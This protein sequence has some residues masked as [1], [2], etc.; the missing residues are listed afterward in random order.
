MQAPEL[1]N[2]SARLRALD[3]AR[4]LDT[5]SEKAYDDLVRLASFICG[6]P[7]SLISLVDQKRQWFKARVGLDVKETAR[8]LA[9]CAHTILKPDGLTV[10]EDAAADARFADNPLVTGDPNIRFYAGAPLVTRDG[11]ALGSLCVIDRVPRTLTPQQVDAL[12]TIRTQ[13][14]REM[15]LRR[16][17]VDL[18]NSYAMLE[19]TQG[20]VRESER[21]YRELVD[22]SLGLICVHD[23]EGTLTLVNPAVHERLGYLPG[24]LKGKNLASIIAPA[25]RHLFPDYLRRI[26]E[27]LADSGLMR[28]VT[29]AG[30]ERVWHYR[31]VL[32]LEDNGKTEVIGHAEDVTDSQ[33]L[34]RTLRMQ[35]AQD[36]LTKLFNRRYLEDAMEREI[37]KALRR[38]RSVSLLMIDVDF[39]KRIN[40]SH[41]HAA[42]DKVLVALANFLKQGI[43]AEDLACRYGGDEFVVVLTEAGMQGAKVR[44]EK[45]RETVKA[46][47][48]THEATLI[49]GLSLSIGVAAYPANGQ[50]LRELLDAADKALYR[51][52]LHGRDQVC[53]AEEAAVAS[54]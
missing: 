15:E 6:T 39:Y 36:P 26:G 3:D 17:A 2:E 20:R 10:V 30:D 9:F 40:D 25:T 21:R 29:K 4:I 16:N 14:I 31:N 45:L 1:S 33:K 44:A 35:V 28:V 5:P 51:A 27:N 34:E 7:I 42:G 13:V 53:L 49:E 12:E 50:T 37:R 23:L 11:F 41:G 18:A 54:D 52:K 38:K 32:R 43:R 19:E 48:V 24:E 8:E 22:N 47:K 46:V